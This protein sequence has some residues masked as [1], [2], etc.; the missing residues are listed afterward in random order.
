MKNCRQPLV[1]THVEVR[2]ETVA[3]HGPL[4][5]IR[6]VKLLVQLEEVV[7]N[8]LGDGVEAPEALLERH[9]AGLL[10]DD[11]ELLREERLDVET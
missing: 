5:H 2:S 9:C 3:V 1:G 10:V 11:V 4:L 8:V 6:G 7:H